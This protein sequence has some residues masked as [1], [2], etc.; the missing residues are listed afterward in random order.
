MNNGSIHI[1]AHAENSPLEYSI[2]GGI[3]IADSNFTSLPAGIYE[4][5]VKDT[6]GCIVD[7]LINI[8]NLDGPEIDSLQ[9]VPEYCGLQNGEITIIAWSC[10]FGFQYIFRTSKWYLS[11][12]SSGW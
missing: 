5:L 12:H 10:F 9:I 6:F 8:P 7:Q 2:G 4:I 11:D 3:F 1:H